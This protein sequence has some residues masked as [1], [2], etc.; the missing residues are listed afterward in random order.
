MY[1]YKNSNTVTHQ[2]FG[3]RIFTT[4]VQA[5]KKKKVLRSLMGQKHRSWHAW[6]F[7]A[8]RQK[9]SSYWGAYRVPN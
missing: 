2:D 6:L 8:N 4:A 1:A 7:F 9:A 5:Q 3:G